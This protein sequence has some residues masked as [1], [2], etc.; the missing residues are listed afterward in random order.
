MAS[1]KL[2]SGMY[3]KTLKEAK[4][5]DPNT[6]HLLGTLPVGT[7]CKIDR[8]AALLLEEKTVLAVLVVYNAVQYVFMLDSL[9][10]ATQNFEIL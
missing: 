5:Y 10:D 1:I 6:F 9:A 7:E 3:V 2:D 8:V 4:L